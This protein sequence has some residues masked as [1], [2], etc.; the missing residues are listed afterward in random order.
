[1][2]QLETG[3]DNGAIDIRVGEESLDNADRDS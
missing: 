1:M 3:E 2:D